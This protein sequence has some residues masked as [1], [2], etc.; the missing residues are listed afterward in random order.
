MNFSTKIENDNSSYYLMHILRLDCCRVAKY[1]LLKELVN[2][3]VYPIVNNDI[4][5]KN[6]N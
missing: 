1:Y 2:I 6:R 5:M 4:V 3:V